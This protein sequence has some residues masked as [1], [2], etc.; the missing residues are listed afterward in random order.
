[1]HAEALHHL[2]GVAEAQLVQFA[3]TQA[4]EFEAVG[5]LVH[6]LED[7]RKRV[8]EGA[9]E[10]EDDQRIAHAPALSP[11][12]AQAASPSRA[13]LFAGPSRPADGS[14]AGASRSRWCCRAARPGR[15]G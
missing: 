11:A 12:L 5:H 1:R 7:P 2:T 14:A 6:G 9:V 3:V 8:R 10:V 15:R 13:L 4:A